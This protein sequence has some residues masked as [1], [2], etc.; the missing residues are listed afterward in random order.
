MQQ[1]GNWALQAPCICA[2]SQWTCV[3]SGF[4]M[5]CTLQWVKEK[6]NVIVINV[7]PQSNHHLKLVI[8]WKGTGTYQ[9]CHFQPSGS[10][11]NC[12][13]AHNRTCE[14]LNMVEAPRGPYRDPENALLTP[15]TLTCSVQQNI[16]ILLSYHI[17]ISRLFQ[18]AVTCPLII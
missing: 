7:G 6:L 10:E 8:D 9:W 11:A 5:K 4:N 18:G 16:I 1:K 13:N 12:S 15:P 2:H 3:T 14:W 17:V